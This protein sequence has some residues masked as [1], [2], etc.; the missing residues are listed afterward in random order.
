[1][2]VDV[3]TYVCVRLGVGRKRKKLSKL[4]G[5]KEETGV[6]QGKGQFVTT[7]RGASRKKVFLWCT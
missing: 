5:H 6:L 2:C 1:M 7:F 4:R 3:C